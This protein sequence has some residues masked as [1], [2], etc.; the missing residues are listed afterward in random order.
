MAEST[1]KKIV[2]IHLGTDNFKTVMTAGQHE[3]ISDE[4]KNIGGSDEG[5]DPYDYL[6]MSLGSCTV[7]TIRMYAERK[8]WDFKNIY[9]E[10]RHQKDYAEDCKDCDDPKAK[11]DVIEKEIIIEGDLS[12]DQLERLLEISKKC[13]VHKTMQGDLE[14]KST[15]ERK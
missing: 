10:L 7:I 8:G 4:P 3:L 12:D 5:P 13:P 1:K 15:I 2:H 6:M 14:L 11:I 9:M